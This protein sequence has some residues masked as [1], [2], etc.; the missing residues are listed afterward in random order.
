M[1]SE[2]PVLQGMSDPTPNPSLID[3]AKTHNRAQKNKTDR[4]EATA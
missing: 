4:Q 2:K 3:R 1:G